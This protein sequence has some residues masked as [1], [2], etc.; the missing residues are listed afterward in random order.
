MRFIQL[1][2]VVAALAVAGC[3]SVETSGREPLRNGERE[4]SVSTT[5]AASGGFGEEVIAWHWAV[6]E[7]IALCMAERGFDYV[8]YV[9]QPMLD[10]LRARYD[11]NL[12]EIK[13]DVDEYWAPLL[14]M[15]SSPGSVSQ[16]EGML[17]MARR[18]GFNI[19]FEPEGRALPGPDDDLTANPNAAIV[20]GLVN[21]EQDEYWRALQGYA[22]G[23]IE[24]GNEPSEAAI[25]DACSVV[26]R[27][28]AGFEPVPPT[29]LDAVDLEKLDVLGD[30]VFRLAHADARLDV[31]GVERV[32]CLADRGLPPDPYEYIL[33]LLR[34]ET[35]RVTGDP[36][37]FIEEGYSEAGKAEAFGADR[38]RELQAEELAAAVGGTECGMPYSQV[39]RD[40]INEYEQ[41]VLADNPDIAAL[42]DRDG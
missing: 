6:E 14:P 33:G 37:G 41:Q 1:L 7:E 17:E 12:L 39:L 28:L 15:E 11:E 27:G 13:P 40:L 22:A 38:L 10:S 42:L 2:A 24:G 34:S 5:A 20:Q 26:A 18:T 19:F 21:E 30:K 31:A 9:P 23:D 25:Q 32:A 35:E 8:P 16:A 4:P 3:Q 29:Q 36:Q